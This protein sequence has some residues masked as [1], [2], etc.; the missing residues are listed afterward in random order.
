M[1]PQLAV[2]IFRILGS[3]NRKGRRERENFNSV[4]DLAPFSYLHL[5]FCGHW[6]CSSF[7]LWGRW[8]VSPWS[9]EHGC[10]G[11]LQ[12][13]LQN[14]LEGTLLISKAPNSNDSTLPVRYPTSQPL[15]CD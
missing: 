6:L 8:I 9:M 13:M 14:D 5:L 1:Y 10:L 3:I 4:I 11:F 12:L 2:G 15:L 7:S